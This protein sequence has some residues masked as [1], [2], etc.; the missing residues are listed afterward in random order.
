MKKIFFNVPS[1]FQ[2]YFR[3]SNR[4]N[5]L[6]ILLWSSQTDPIV[7]SIIDDS[8]SNATYLS[9]QVQNELL[10]IMANQVRRKIAEK[11]SNFYM[12]Y[13]QC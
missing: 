1:I 7:K 5:F 8:S 12:K 10:E 4:G 9:H 11:V 13:S 3:S 2:K 6:E